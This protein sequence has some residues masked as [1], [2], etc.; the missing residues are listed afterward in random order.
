MAEAS[1]LWQQ[2]LFFVLAPSIMALLVSI[3]SRGW[4]KTVQG[5]NVIEKTLK[6]PRL[7]FWIVLCFMYVMLF[8]I[9]LYGHFQHH[10]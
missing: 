10:K 1:P 7:K 3:L 8:C 5:G 4:A 2:A 9:F 6:R